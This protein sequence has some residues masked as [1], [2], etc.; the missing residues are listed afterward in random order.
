MENNNSISDERNPEELNIEEA[1]AEYSND[2]INIEDGYDVLSL[3]EK[4]STEFIDSDLNFASLNSLKEMFN[5]EKNQ[6]MYEIVSAKENEQNMYLEVREDILNK[7]SPKQLLMQM[8]LQIETLS[9]RSSNGGFDYGMRRETQRALSTTVELFEQRAV[10]FKDGRMEPNQEDY[11]LF[12]VATDMINELKASTKDV[13]RMAEIQGNTALFVMRTNAARS[14][15]QFEKTQEDI[16]R[17]ENEYREAINGK[18]LSL[19]A[20]DGKVF[21][22]N[23]DNAFTQAELFTDEGFAKRFSKA[24]KAALELKKSETAKKDERLK[25]IKANAER[26]TEKAKAKHEA[27]KKKIE[28]TYRE[29]LEA[30]NRLNEKIKL[31]GSSPDSEDIRQRDELEPEVK[32]RQRLLEKNDAELEA[33]KQSI[34][35]TLVKD[36]NQASNEYF[37]AIK[38]SEKELQSFKR[39]A[40][41]VSAFKEPI[42]ELKKGAKQMVNDTEKLKNEVNKTAEEMNREIL[43]S[44]LRTQDNLLDRLE[45]SGKTFGGDSALF[46]NV[47]NGIEAF[48]QAR[49]G[50]NGSFSLD[51]W[52]ECK[53][54]LQK[55]LEDYIKERDNGNKRKSTVKGQ[56]RLDTA[57]MLLNNLNQATHKMEE[58]DKEKKAELSSI[59]CKAEARS[60]IERS[61][62]SL[63]DGARKN[64][65]K[66]EPN[67]PK[68]ENER[69]LVLNN[70]FN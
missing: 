39:L 58:I 70:S 10:D 21:N 36:K 6:L 61:V 44:T 48:R 27:E 7:M 64:P 15:A 22:I 54:G 8:K 68:K 51:E 35:N 41:M 60:D 24:T 17:F 67:S 59:S 23:A 42:A 69:V 46:K 66:E 38:D 2:E 45:A 52:N 47:K 31:A 37:L 50:L 40:E 18:E 65:V 5:P 32:E 30:Y 11:R 3:D 62:F 13:K 53:K 56:I 34:G 57:K 33:A 4:L 29:K 25:A 63:A 26:E 9:E 55:S 43:N 28:D 20:D 1:S 16:L 12:A 14:K 19:K 49:N